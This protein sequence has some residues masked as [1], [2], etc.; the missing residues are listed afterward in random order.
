M[1]I[2]IQRYT[3]YT[4]HEGREPSRRLQGKRMLANYD[5]CKVELKKELQLLFTTY[6]ESLDSAST[7]LSMFP[8]QSRSRILEASIIQ[9]CF[10]ESLM[11][12]FGERAFFG[13]YKRLILRLNGYVILFKK[14]DSKGF[15]MNIKTLNVQSILN[16]NQVLDLFAE[17]DYNDKPILYFG[18]Q[19]NRLGEY[20]NPQLIYIDEGEIK[21]SILEDDLQLE[22]PLKTKIAVEDDQTNEVKPKLKENKSIRKAK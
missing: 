17:S 11:K 12:N 15:P 4:Q 3:N 22:L 8:P 6:N 7:M 1:N 21:F 5:A 20:V 2:N 14:L 16:Q 9:S 13:K 19:K 10:A 18:Y